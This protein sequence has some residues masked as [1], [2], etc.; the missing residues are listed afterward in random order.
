MQTTVLFVISSLRPC[1]PV[2]QLSYILR[3]LDRETFSPVVVR[4]SR[5]KERSMKPLFREMGVPV[6]TV[7]FSKAGLAMG[8]RKVR[9]RILRE[10]SPDII[11]V[12]GLRADG[13]FSGLE[14]VPVISSVR[15][16]PGDEYIHRFGWAAGKAM[17]ALHIR[18]MKRIC[19][20]VACSD[21]VAMRYGEKTGIPFL[22][23][24]NGVDTDFFAPASPDLK[25][26]R[27]QELGLDEKKVVFISSGVLSR[28]K[29]PALLI[30]SFLKSRWRDDG[31]LILAGEMKDR[32]RAEGLSRSNILFTGP[33]DDILRWYQ[34]S[35]V[36]L[37]ASRS[38]G[39]PN[40]VLEGMS[41]GLPAF[42]SDIPPHA[43]ILDHCP[44][45]GSLFRS[46]EGLTQLLVEAGKTQAGGMGKAAATGV[47]RHFSAEKMSLEFQDLY[48]KVIAASESLPDE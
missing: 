48:R 18:Y 7:P 44:D 30:R 42:L 6:H 1:G 9:N 43:H 34:A 32:V 16:Y 31:L 14:G 25:K 8:K 20:P 36:L 23:I 24:D 39:L 45:A 3:Y 22:H 38:E 41:C 13:L 17:A 26:K 33:V 27:R 11:H 29:N 19:I 4:L 15:N 2:R 35:D 46:E 5:E 28:R 10:F 40:A 21:Y 12:H 47:R 37:S